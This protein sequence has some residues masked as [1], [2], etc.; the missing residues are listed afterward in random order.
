VNT[1]THDIEVSGIPVEVVRKDIKNLHL[2]VYPPN[3]RV[4]VAAPLRVSDEAVRLAVVSRLGWVRRQQKRFEAQERQSPREMV[5][6]ETHYFRGH[7]YRLDVVE[8]DIGI[9]VRRR[10]NNRLELRVRPGLTRA[11]RE[12]VLAAWYRETLREQVDVLLRKWAPK[13]RV[14]V[15]QWGI[16]KMKTRWGT[17]SNATRRIWFNLELAK[18]SPACVELIVVHELVH[19]L[20][21]HHDES[22]INEMTRHL[23]NWRGVRD[24]LN[25]APLG[26]YGW[27]Y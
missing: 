8:T 23:P 19:L 3:G 15:N 9:G 18:K 4:R 24:E 21:R 16:R 27:E 10:T 12:R 13:I 5:S 17:C 11:A 6:G 14:C 2:G 26:N 7:R 22:F 20:H 25:R 1:K